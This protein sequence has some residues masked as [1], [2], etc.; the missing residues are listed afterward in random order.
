MTFLTSASPVWN[1]WGRNPSYVVVLLE[2]TAWLSKRPEQLQSFLVGD[3]IMVGGNPME[4][5]ERVQFAAPPREGE[6]GGIQTATFIQTDRPGFYTV[7]RRTRSG[8]DVL[9]LKAINVSTAEGDIRQL[10]VTEIVDILRPVRQSLETAANFSMVGDFDQGQSVSDW[11]F[12]MV[13]LF[14]V[15]EIFLAG[16]ILPSR[17][18][19][20]T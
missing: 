15:G 2:L 19:P 14:L 17:S 11:L 5:E 13:I 12:Y 18:E 20:A 10:D 16:R 8:A 9:E 1:N 6:L 4:Y 3:S 7:H